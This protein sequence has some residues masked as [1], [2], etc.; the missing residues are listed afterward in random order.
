[1]KRRTPLSE[2][3][4]W[5]L[6]TCAEN[7]GTMLVRDLLEPG[8]PNVERTSLSRTIRRLARRQ[9]VRLFQRSRQPGEPPR[10]R[11]YI[12]RVMLTDAGRA[13]VHS[14]ECEDGPV[15][16]IQEIAAREA[17]T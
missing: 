14:L 17:R 10:Q 6:T 16:A 2:P 3:M 1:M 5:V 12:R 15:S 8:S 9:L 13:A 4:R 11:N 7:G